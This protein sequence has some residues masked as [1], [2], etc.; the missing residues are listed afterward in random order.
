MKLFY[1]DTD[2]LDIGDGY[3]IYF[4]FSKLIELYNRKKEFTVHKWYLNK[5]ILISKIQS[6]V[7]F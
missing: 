1:F 4:H 5:P 7:L 3:I 2:Y 6:K